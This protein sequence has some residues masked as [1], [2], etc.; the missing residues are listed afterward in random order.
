MA[1]K[2]FSDEAWEGFGLM[3]KLSCMCLRTRI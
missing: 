1:G 2:G 3:N